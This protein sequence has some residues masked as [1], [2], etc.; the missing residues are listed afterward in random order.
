MSVAK[1]VTEVGPQLAWMTIQ[2]T[3]GDEWRYTRKGVIDS[4]KIPP[5]LRNVP[6][7]LRSEHGSVVLVLDDEGEPYLRQEEKGLPVTLKL[8]EYIS[9]PAPAIGVMVAWGGRFVKYEQES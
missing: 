2:D 3:D 6:P 1:T 4:A 7:H 5:H 9:Q 8:S